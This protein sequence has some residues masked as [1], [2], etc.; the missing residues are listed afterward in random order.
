[1]GK[2]LTKDEISAVIAKAI[3]NSEHFTDSKLA[4]ER[5]NVLS[6][7][8]GE[9]PK[10]LHKGDS[11]YVSRDVFDS[12]DSMRSTVLEAYS[13]SNRI[14]YFRPERGETVDDAKQA[15]EFTQ[16][17]F[18][19]DNA[20]EDL[21]YSTC[22]DALLGRIG[23]L[24][25]FYD[26][27]TLEDDFEFEALTPEE[28]TAAVSQHDSYEFVETEIT[29]EGLYS[30]TYRVFTHKK[31]IKVIAIP[32]EDFLIASG[33]ETI[34]T[35]RFVCHRSLKTR[36][37]F[38]ETYG[39]T[40]AEKMRYGAS[41]DHLFD[42]E[43]SQR[44][45]SIGSGLM[46]DG[47]DPATAE[48]AFYECY[49]RADLEGGGKARL[50]KVSYAGGEVLDKERVSVVPFAAY[51]PLPIP[52][53]Y[54][55][56]NFAAAVIPVQNARTVLIRQIINHSLMTNN[57]RQ[58]VLNGTLA[59]PAELLDNRLGGI[60]NVR[61][62]DGIAAIPQ[63]PLNPYVFSLIQMIDEDKEEVTG[64]S[65][66]SQGLNKDAISSQNA[67]GMVEQ[68]I[69]A[70]QQ[71][72]KTIARRFGVFMKDLFFLIYNT[73]VDHMDQ[74]TVV[75]LSGV[76][77]EVNPAHWKHRSAAS[78]E[79]TLGYGEREREAQKWQGIDAMFSQDPMLA[80][81]YTY[82]RRYQVIRRG[83]EQIGVEDLETFLTPPE[84][85]QPPEPDPMQELQ[86]E[87]LKTQIEYAKAQATAMTA[88]AET[89]RMKAETD[90]MRIQSD[91]ATRRFDSDT[92]RQKVENDFW[93][94]QEELRLA[95]AADTQK[96]FYNP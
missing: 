50:W 73:A 44:M 79:L 2:K 23:V 39:E 48:A 19:R 11:K 9:A 56:D 38:V 37:W 34:Q 91:T 89:D 29:P 3:S 95:E 12:V 5:S 10:P 36:S 64:I 84:E 87:M 45:Y 51:V 55:G 27:E 49:I 17:V 58:Q 72:T 42:Y 62:L 78:I 26:E 22:T 25:V 71:R 13:A 8:R 61:R 90:R 76:E 59:N 92:K 40:V 67:E 7:Y 31:G 60:V 54:I 35:A 1:M 41:S 80:P 66:L 46:D 93:V 15:T 6:Y 88:K 43:K 30:G 14:V 16:Q 63:A 24:K 21:L 18:F 77:A 85:V 20:G 86:M 94:D 70:S 82:D 65:K 32:P 28:L 83:L 75:E 57:P 81:Q 53:T 96:A 68:L 33:A 74:Q 47:H 69:S 52:H 4:S